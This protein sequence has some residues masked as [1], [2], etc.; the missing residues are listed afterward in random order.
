MKNFDH[1]EYSKQREFHNS[2]NSVAAVLNCINE[3][4]LEKSSKSQEE[5]GKYFRRLLKLNLWGNRNDLSVSLGVEIANGNESNPI[6]EIESFNEFLVVDQTHEIWRCFSDRNKKNGIVDIVNDNS[7]YELMCDFI[8]ADFIL[9]HNLAE[10]IRFHVKAIPWFIS[11]VTPVDFYWSLDQLTNSSN[12]ILRKTGQKWQKYVTDKKF[13]LIEP[14]S[15]FWTSGLEFHRME[16][17]NPNLY[18]LIS[19]CHLAI[20]K[21]DLNY[22]KLLGDVNWDTTTDFPTVLQGFR[23]TNL[24]TLRTVKADLVC[25]MKTGEAENLKEKDSKW[26][27]TGKYGVIQFAPK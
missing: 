18:N 14:P 22:R 6:E 20:F 1:F 8:L 13:V 4:N 12:E 5:I 25:G 7:G 11:D 9:E 10:T 26:M 15:H 21:G 2:L 19:E 16:S 17:V 3:F 27:E 24:C 23:P